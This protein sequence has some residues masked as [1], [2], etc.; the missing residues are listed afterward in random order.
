MVP[1]S[2]TKNLLSLFSCYISNLRLHPHVSGHF[3]KR[4]FFL[5]VSAFRSNKNAVFGHRKWR[6]SNTAPIVEAFENAIA[7][8][9]LV[10]DGLK[11]GFLNSMRSYIHTSSMRTLCKGCYR[12]SIV[13]AFSY[14][15]V[16]TVQ[17]HH[18][19]THFGWKR[20]KKI[21]VFQTIS[22]YTWTP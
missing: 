11:R 17:I 21:S 20:N 2:L 16:K 8:R 4:I 19:W 6:F 5:S 18:V 3:W 7:S 14:G 15:R 13:L 1:F 22:G 12:I 9:L 10:P